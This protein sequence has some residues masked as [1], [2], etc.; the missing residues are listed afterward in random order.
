METINNIELRDESIYPDEQVLK[1]I[2]GESHPAY[3][4]LLTLFDKNEMNYEWRYYHD[5]KAWL[6]KVQKKKKTIVWMSAWKGFMKAT[7]YIPERYI[8]EIYT[9]N[10]GEERKE[11]IRQTI[12]SGKSKPCIFE[13]RNRDVLEELNEIMQFKIKT[14]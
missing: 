14:R 2:L 9:L 10:I 13:I 1:H 12:N 5:G 11:K 8:K 4:D 3:L 7:I 6:C